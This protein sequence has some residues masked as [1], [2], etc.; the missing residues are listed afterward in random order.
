MMKDHI[1]I[2]QIKDFFG[3]N[4]LE[5]NEDKIEILKKHIKKEDSIKFLEF[6]SFCEDVKM[7][8]LN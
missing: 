7:Y 5:L 6:D 3:K 2:S 8:A 1:S 4:N